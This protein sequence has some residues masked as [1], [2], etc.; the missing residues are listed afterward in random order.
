VTNRLE[1]KA[2]TQQRI[3]IAATEL[4]VEHGYEGTTISAVAEGAEV[5]RATVFWHFGDKGGLFRE[6]FSRLLDPFRKSLE[7][8]FLDLEPEKRLHEQLAMSEHFAHD[9]GSEIAAFLRWAL[10]DPDHRDGVVTTLLDLNQR[11]AGA[12]TQSVAALAPAESN[13]KLLALVLM[14]AFD[15]NLLLS[16]FD[17]E[18]RGGE[19]RRAAIQAYADLIVRSNPPKA[20]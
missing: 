8:E 18:S 7:Q 6:A 11:F 13:P 4:F 16:L 5:S 2:A 12:L 17:K 20:G 10:E 1:G 14:L 19:E 3:L 9:H 15:G